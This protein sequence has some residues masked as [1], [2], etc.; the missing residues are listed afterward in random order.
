MSTTQGSTTFKQHNGN[1]AMTLAEG[2]WI[3]IPIL[4]G[5]LKSVGVSDKPDFDT[6]NIG[7]LF[8]QNDTT[9]ALGYTMQVNHDIKKGS[10]I[11]PHV[12]FIQTGSG[13]AVFKYSY[14]VYNVGEAVPAFSSAITQT[15]YAITYA[16][17]SIHQIAIL[18]EIT[19]TGKTESCLIDI[20]VWRDDNVVTGDVLVKSIDAHGLRNRN[21]S[22]SEYGDSF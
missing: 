19:M 15:G 1:N 4:G 21:G 12:H 7:W 6:T 8:P 17:G 5:S 11:R 3:D 20:K 22:V 18:P 16:S 9:E 14:R 13:V 10:P 2:E